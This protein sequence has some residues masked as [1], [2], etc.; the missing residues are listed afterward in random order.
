MAENY[1][2]EFLLKDKSRFLCRPV[3]LEDC[4]KLEEFF[5]GIPELDIQIFRDEVISEEKIE[6]WLISTFKKKYLQLIVLFNNR[7]IAIGT[8][9]PGKNYL[10]STA[11]INII[12]T[13]EQ[14]RKG[15]GSR[16]FDL[17]LYEGLEIGMQK[18]IVRYASDNKGIIKLLNN[19]GFETELSLNYNI[20]DK[21][22]KS[23]KN[24]I[25][26]SL[27]IQEWKR[28]FEFYNPEPK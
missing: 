19:Y 6:D 20:N 23:H 8:L 21:E 2:L 28:R 24:I 15:I 11:E 5:I 3:K 1:P 16:L 18:L 4:K 26:S 27:N 7:I 10:E 9:K 13:P 14:R 25:V 22:N 17:L 12:V